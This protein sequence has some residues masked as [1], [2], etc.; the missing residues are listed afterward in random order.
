MNVIGIVF[1]IIVIFLVLLVTL[2]ALVNEHEFQS[3]LMWG[4][5]ED[6]YD[7]E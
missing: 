3:P 2:M 5:I 7:G 4:E 6:E 1:L